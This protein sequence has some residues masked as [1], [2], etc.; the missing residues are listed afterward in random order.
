[1]PS[2]WLNAL[3]KY[4]YP[5]KL[6]DYSSAK[7]YTN[8]FN[9]EITGARESTVNF[10]N[11]FR[12]NCENIEVWYEVVF[13]KMYSQKSRSDN[14]TTALIEQLKIYKL[15]ANHLIIKLQSFIDEPTYDN[16]DGFRKLFHFKSKVI[17]I[18]A[19]FPA[20]LNPMQFPMVDT[21]TARWVNSQLEIHNSHDLNSPKLIKS[22]YRNTNKAPVL[23]MDDFDFYLHWIKW[24]RYMATK[25]S[26][27]TEMKWRARDVEM[28]VF[29]AW[30]DRF[31]THPSLKLNPI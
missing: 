8:T 3:T 11:Y 18:I 6:S 20:F 1:M 7:N 25:L 27:I 22:A 17:A 4:N 14:R 9:L 28:A 19:T 12:D 21:R 23:T 2:T 10:E 30:G 29:T 15:A 26:Q 31:C 13:W 24:T 16:F 5:V